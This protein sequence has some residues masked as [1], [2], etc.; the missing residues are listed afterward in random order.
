MTRSTVADP[1]WDAALHATVNDT[2]AHLQYVVFDRRWEDIRAN[3]ASDEAALRQSLLIYEQ[4][5][6]DLL[7]IIRLL[8][9]C[10]SGTA[11]SEFKAR[12][13]RDARES[14]A[15]ISLR[16]ALDEALYQA[17][18]HAAGD[19]A[20]YA[21]WSAGLCRVLTDR[22]AT[23]PPRPAQSDD[24]D[25]RLAWALAC[26][27]DL[28]DHETFQQALLAAIESDVSQPHS[29]RDAA[30]AL[31]QRLFDEPRYDLLLNFAL[32]IFSDCD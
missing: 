30:R 16:T 17:E 14:G 18:Q 26:L 2:I 28:E 9:V 6:A 25:A 19:P 1:C 27:A 24:G 32:R 20:T 5:L 15:E 21:A 3:A 13:R 4:G 31:Q 22:R 10:A 23:C 12:L 7:R 11:W 8:G 29:A